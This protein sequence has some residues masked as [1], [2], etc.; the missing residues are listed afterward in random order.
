MKHPSLKTYEKMVS[1]AKSDGGTYKVIGYVRGGTLHST[2]KNG[3]GYRFAYVF[4]DDNGNE[5]TIKKQEAIELAGTG[6]V[7]NAKAN[8]KRDGLNGITGDLRNLK[9]I[10]PKNLSEYL[11]EEEIE[12]IEKILDNS[13][14]K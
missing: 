4:V 5:Y 2:E 10:I 1:K 12:R 9:E 7:K 14:V 11:S 8:S 3:P 13:T 6:L